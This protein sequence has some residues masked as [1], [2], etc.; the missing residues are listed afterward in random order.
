ME[1]LLRY[2]LTTELY[3]TR[4][5]DKQQF[6]CLNDGCLKIFANRDEFEVHTSSH[7]DL[8]IKEHSSL[9]IS[10]EYTAAVQNVEPD[11]RD[12][13]ETTSP[14]AADSNIGNQS[15]RNSNRLKSS[16]VIVT[17]SPSSPP[18]SST[19]LFSSSICTILRRGRSSGT[20]PP[21]GMQTV[22]EVA[23][24]DRQVVEEVLKGPDLS[25]SR[26]LQQFS[27]SSR[28]NIENGMKIVPSEKSKTN[29]RCT[30][31]ITLESADSRKRGNDNLNSRIASKRKKGR[32][33]AE[34][35]KSG[36][37]YSDTDSCEDNSESE[38][39]NKMKN[40]DSKPTDGTEFICPVSTCGRSFSKVISFPSLDLLD[41]V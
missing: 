11:L 39:E 38:S 25:H 32:P 37:E 17:N 23:L 41:F 2:Y 18:S 7:S 16:L 1:N 12:E 6:V 20:V 22:S 9:L 4:L 33:F 36:S 31:N 19:P 8:S 29:D 26:P 27:V 34:M 5:T 40:H 24:P 10:S 30:S 14:D 13:E 28:N 3:I 15:L 35:L 21:R